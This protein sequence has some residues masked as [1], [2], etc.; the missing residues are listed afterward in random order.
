MVVSSIRVVVT[1]VVGI[2]MY[3][4]VDLDGLK[5]L[6]DSV[7]TPVWHRPVKWYAQASNHKRGCI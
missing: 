3:P 2:S 5:S 6:T 4:L 7:C 1:L